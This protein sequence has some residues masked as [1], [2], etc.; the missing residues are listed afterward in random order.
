MGKNDKDLI[1]TNQKKKPKKS[2]KETVTLMIRK[3]WLS[4]TTET[5]LLVV[6]LIALFISFNLYIQSLDLKQIDVTENKLY[7]LSEGSEELIKKIDKDVTIYLYGIGEDSSLAD[8]IRQYERANEHIKCEILTEETNLA[9]VQE[10]DLSS[11]YSIVVLECGETTKLIDASNEFASYDYTT[12]QEVDLTEQVLTNSLLALTTENKPNVYFTI[13]HDEYAIDSEMVVL[14][15]FL[16]NESYNF[17][18]TNLLTEGKVPD[19]CDLLVIVAPVKDFVEQE[20]ESVLA[21]IRTGGNIMFMLDVGNLSET[22]PNLQKIC[23][24]YGVT[25]NHKGYIYETNGDYAL[26]NYPNI[27]MPRV[28]ASHDITSEIYSDGKSTLWLTYSGRLET[29]SE[30]E[31][32]NLNV[33][34]EDLLTSSDEALF[35]ADI[36]LSTDEAAKTAEEGKSIISAIFTK[37]ISDSNTENTEGSSD[38]KDSNNQNTVAEANTTENNESNTNSENTSE[39]TASN[40]ENN[41]SEEKVES[42]AIFSANASFVTDYKVEQ[43]SAQYP[44]SYLAKNKDYMLNSISFLTKKDDVLKIRKDMSTSTYAPTDLQ[45]RIV[46]GITFGV[47]VF[48]ICTG[49]VIWN[50]RRRK[51]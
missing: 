51:R 25:I 24:E 4:N 30:D 13:G 19:D 3:R 8:F 35:V 41:N 11:G 48:L 23:D 1:E 12:G 6:A 31:L 33:K 22:Y 43:L 49:V 20:V 34:K 27:F 26:A 38:N 18:N 40:T 16:K 28:S 37:T 39:E 50:F 44:I 47:P 9:K 21:Y 45:H 42:I 29:K 17:S 46:M 36:T 10:F 15:N 14:S 5:F 2:F 7:T 32:K